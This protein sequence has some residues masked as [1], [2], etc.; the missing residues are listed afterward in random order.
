M[1]VHMYAE[2]QRDVNVD[3]GVVRDEFDIEAVHFCDD[4]V[5]G[6]W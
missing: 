1:L 4:L 6:G 5:G 3:F 2:S